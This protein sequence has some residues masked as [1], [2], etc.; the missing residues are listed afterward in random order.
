MGRVSCALGRAGN[1]TAIRMLP[2]R[3][4]YSMRISMQIGSN[5]ISVR[6]HFYTPLSSPPVM[7]DRPPR[8]MMGEIEVPFGG[9]QLHAEREEEEV[10]QVDDKISFAVDCFNFCVPTSPN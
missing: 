1:G 6:S 2:L 4:A 5:F 7:F 9:V 8:G 10:E 3:N